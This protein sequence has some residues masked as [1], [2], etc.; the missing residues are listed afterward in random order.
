ME[1]TMPPILTLASSLCVIAAVFG[2][3]RPLAATPSSA[4][5]AS[6]SEVYGKLPLTFEANEGQVDRSV[7][8]LSRGQG[9]TLFLTPAEAVLSLRRAEYGTAVVRMQLVGANRA[10]RL[11]GEDLQPTQSNY[12]IGNDS[13]QWHTGVA[14]YARV[15]V[16]RVYPGVDL[17]YRGNQRQLEYD[18]VV[19]AVND[20]RRDG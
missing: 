10:P 6:I 9:T 2:G 12:F 19:A 3:A 16:E 5:G 18:L 13:R 4:A 8:F 11:V 14:H 15:R 7:K 20:A 17:L 1:G